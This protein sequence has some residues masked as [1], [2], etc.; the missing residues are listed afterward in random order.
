MITTDELLGRK[1]RLQNDRDFPLPEGLVEGQ[2]VTIMGY[3][4]R[5]GRVIVS[6]ASGEEWHV[7]AA[8]LQQ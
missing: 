5:R 3:V 2:G 7:R 4:P 1:V 8:N 6:D